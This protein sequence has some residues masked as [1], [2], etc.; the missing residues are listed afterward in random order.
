MNFLVRFIVCCRCREWALCLCIF[1][2]LLWCILTHKFSPVH[3]IFCIELWNLDCGRL[4]YKLCSVSPVLITKCG[5]EASDR[6]S[7][8]FSPF[9]SKQFTGTLVKLYYLQR[10]TSISSRYFQYLPIYDFYW[11]SDYFL[12]KNSLCLISEDVI[13]LL[14][15]SSFSSEFGFIHL[16][17]R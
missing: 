10:E 13:K 1:F 9:L 3:L 8:F 5:D 7:N 4:P 6:R 2:I 15:R 12:D 11:I 16:S 14:V 17:W